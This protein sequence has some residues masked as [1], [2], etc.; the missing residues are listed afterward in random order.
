MD[1]PGGTPWN[2]GITVWRNP[3]Y[4]PNFDAGYVYTFAPLSNPNMILDAQGLYLADYYQSSMLDTS[5]FLIVAHGSNWVIKEL[6]NQSLCADGGTSATG[7][8]I[9]M[10]SCSGA[11]AQDWTFTPQPTKDGAFLIQSAAT[12]LCMHLKSTD[13]SANTG[14]ATYGCN[15][16]SPSER[17]IV[18]A[19]QTTTP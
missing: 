7:G 16:T 19:V 5:K 10:V 14:I 18:Q 6:T 4:T 12:G 11:A 17:F 8:S 9:H 2:Y 1:M 3:N 15:A 13:G